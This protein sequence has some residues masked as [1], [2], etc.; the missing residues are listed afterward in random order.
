[1]KY[2]LCKYLLIEY[3]DKKNILI[4]NTL[5]SNFIKIPF[6]N[7]DTFIS[8]IET[9]KTENY[10]TIPK[11]HMDFL[12]SNN[13]IIDKNIDELDAINERYR[14]VC[15]SKEQLTV[16]IL[17]T[18]KCN[19][20][21]IYCYE[22]FILPK[23]SLSTQ[24]YIISF[25]QEKMKEYKSLY[26]NWFGGEP[27]LALD[28]IENLS[29]NFI[30][31]CRELRKPYVS[32]IT[33][34]GYLLSPAVFNRLMKMHILKY[35]ITIDGSKE[36]H[37]K[38]RP[39]LTGEETYETIVKNLI[40]IKSN[41]KSNLF[42]VNIRTN[43]TQNIDFENEDFVRLKSYFEQDKRYTFSINKVIDYSGGNLQN[44]IYSNNEYVENFKNHSSNLKSIRD[45]NADT[46]ICYAAKS[47]SVVIRSD[48]SLNK[49]T[50]HFNDKRNLFG[51]IKD[52]QID[53]SDST[54]IYNNIDKMERCYNCI[55][56][57]ICM[58]I[59]CPA[60]G[61]TCTSE[62]NKIKNLMSNSSEEAI[63]FII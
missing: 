29:N 13:I 38:Q 4:Y 19:F 61:N 49:C 1:M 59:K 22:D 63:T 21:C 11:H 20:R 58:S 34:N 54:Y 26:V 27:L 36:T 14:T 8:I 41:I 33:T 39:L 55:I 25:I 45:L 42:E 24:E 43:I 30:R 44:I 53:I 60:K 17:P 56:F 37:D 40:D 62:V 5:Y 31:I 51:N 9:L 18:E 23:M 50:V 16:I 46:Y 7:T 28:V 12:V 3:D 10:D 47:N 57:P 6:E 32:G 48:G 35:Q 2:K 52:N 15:H